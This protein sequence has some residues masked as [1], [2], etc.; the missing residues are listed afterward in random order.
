MQLSWKMEIIMVNTMAT[1]FL[2]SKSI[3]K[4]EKFSNT[5]Y[6]HVFLSSF[7]RVFILF[8]FEPLPNFLDVSKEALLEIFQFLI[9]YI[10]HPIIFKY[11]SIINNFK[12]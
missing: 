5:G 9:L 4:L 3:S 12:F 2:N 11:F 8:S 1:M 7:P 10:S 6:F